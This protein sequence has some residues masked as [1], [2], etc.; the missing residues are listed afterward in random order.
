VRAGRADRDNSRV[1]DLAITGSTGELG[2]RVARRLA[3]GGVSQ[4]LIVR[5]PSR[6]PRLPG[7][8]SAAASSY[9]AEEEMRA[10]LS[11]ART[12]Y[13]VSGREDPDRLEQ[14]RTVVRAAEA[15]GVERIV[16]VS[17][18][19]AAADATFTLGRHHW[20]T[21]QA[22]RESGLAFTFLRSSLYLDFMPFFAGPERVIRGPAGDGRFA[23]VARDDLADAAVA[24]LVAG[25]EHDGRT[26]NLTG[27]E[28]LTLAEVAARLSAYTGRRFT[29]HAETVEEAW[30]SRRPTGAPDWE[31]E[32]WISSYVAIADGSLAVLTDDVERLTGHPPQ[33]LEQCLSAHREL[34]AESR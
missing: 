10:A 3:E 34:L 31:I 6:A 16:Y 17:F 27:P 29:Y 5:D 21:E 30:T 8:E 12:L 9:G 11:G 19:G 13:F 4:R 23:P 1:T 25:G 22:I 28:L 2:G 20:A 7:A 14:H 15:A 33:T 26:Y 32:G 18:V 24:V